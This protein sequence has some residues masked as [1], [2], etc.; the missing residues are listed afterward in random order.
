ME[1]LTSQQQAVASSKASSGWADTKA[2]G[3]D[4]ENNPNSP[5][6]SMGREGKGTEKGC[7][8]GRRSTIS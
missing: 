7:F 2:P 6:T 1:A 5:E 4:Q 3:M 8:Q